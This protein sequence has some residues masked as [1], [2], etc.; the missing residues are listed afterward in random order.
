MHTVPSRFQEYM[1]GLI[2]HHKYCT[3]VRSHQ[4]LGSI[5]YN[6]IHRGYISIGTVFRNSL[7]GTILFDAAEKCVFLKMH[8][9][10]NTE[11]EMR[12]IIATIYSPSNFLIL[13]SG[14]S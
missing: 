8:L 7:T 13:M 5:C 11:G 12:W 9:R 1:T 10:W 14:K 4:C 2:S 3:P 6:V